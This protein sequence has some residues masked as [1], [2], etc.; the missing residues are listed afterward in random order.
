[1]CF[2]E[3]VTLSISQNLPISGVLNA[4][5]VC[6]LGCQKHHSFS[7]ASRNHEVIS[8]E[9]YLKLPSAILKI[10]TY[11]NEHNSKYQ[12]FCPQHDKICCS[13]CISEYHTTC[14]GLK[15]LQEIVK[16]S[17]ESAWLENIEANL[18]DM[19]Y[20]YDN[21]KKDREQDLASVR[22]QRKH[23]H[24]EIKQIREQINSHLDLLEQ[25][26]IKELNAAEHKIKSAFETLISQ[27]TEKINTVETLQGNISS[28][29]EYASDLQ[30]FLGSKSLETEV[31]REKTYLK[32]L[33]Q[34][35]VFI[36]TKLN[37]T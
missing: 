36:K 23:F 10:A 25:Q 37:V 19:R 3:Y 22:N 28:V 4:M 21:I 1:M 35:G 13:V 9:N 16:T 24:E 29:K 26:I 5:R 33:F 27:I 32:S 20:N 12:N 18:K 34:D 2:A 17:K 7:K 31:E 15:S 30:T 11:C 14:C 6:V 8:I